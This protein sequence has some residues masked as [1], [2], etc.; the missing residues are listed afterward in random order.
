[1]DFA[2]GFELLVECR[3]FDGCKTGKAKITKGYNL[4]AKFVIHTVGPIW[5]GGN[6]NEKEL[7]A[8]S[9]RNYLKLSGENNLKSNAFL[10]INT[11]A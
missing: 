4:P 1:L 7:L 8:N 10:S 6:H 2:A 9:Y 5:R 11:S 3:S